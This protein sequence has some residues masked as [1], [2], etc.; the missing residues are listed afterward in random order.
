MEGNFFSVVGMEDYQR[1]VL[2][3]TGSLCVAL[4]IL[5]SRSSYFPKYWGY[6][7]VLGYM[8]LRNI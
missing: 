4:A 5:N 6:R 3:H 1:V 7:D 8:T 2:F